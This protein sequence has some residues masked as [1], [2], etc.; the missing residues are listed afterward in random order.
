[1]ILQPRYIL[2]C[3]RSLSELTIEKRWFVAMNN[4]LFP[5]E[6]NK[7]IASTNF[8]NYLII[9]DDGIVTNEALNKVVELLEKVE[10]ATGWCQ[11]SKTIPYAN[12]STK[13]LTK[14]VRCPVTMKNYTCPTVQEVL[15]GPEVGI[16]YFA[17]Y[18]FTG[19]RRHIWLKH[20]QHPNEYSGSQQ[21][22]ELSWDLQKSGVTIRYHRD[23]FINHLRKTGVSDMDKSVIG[24]VKPYISLAPYIPPGEKKEPQ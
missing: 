5:Q 16:T 22:F 20:P 1:M 18:C 8:D 2:K 17:G 19:M 4:T 3:I 6:I 9:S 24:K 11:I 12:L 23:A 15:N 14:K 7:F 21:D 10:V 13:P